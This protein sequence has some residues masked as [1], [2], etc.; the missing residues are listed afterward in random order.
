VVEAVKFNRPPAVLYVCPK[1]WRVAVT[2]DFR[3]H[4]NCEG[5]PVKY[6]LDQPR[7]RI[8]A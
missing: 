3:R 4:F 8:V 1:C 7:L 2:P 5:T 6:L